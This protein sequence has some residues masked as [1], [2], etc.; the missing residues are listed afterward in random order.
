MAIVALRKDVCVCAKTC[1]SVYQ[2]YTSKC[3]I[4]WWDYSG[5]RCQLACND[6]QPQR[7]VAVNL[8]ALE[9]YFFVGRSHALQINLLLGVGLG[10]GLV[11]ILLVPCFFAAWNGSNVQEWRCAVFTLGVPSRIPPPHEADA[12][13]S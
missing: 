9:C 13:D 1:A 3:S 10:I 6:L 12:V 7:M 11:V 2:Y 5:D 8:F 4:L